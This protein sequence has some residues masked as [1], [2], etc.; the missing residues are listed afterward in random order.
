MRFHILMLTALVV[1]AGRMNPAM[2]AP[3]GGPFQ[4]NWDSIKANY[5]T[6]EWFKDGKFGIFMHWGLYSVPAHHSEW[7]VQ[8]MYRPGADQQWHIQNFGPVDKFGYKDF[9]PGFTAAKWDPDAWA[10]LF[11][12]AGVR[13]IVPT[14][15]HHD[16]FSLWDSALNKYNAKN[17]G[18]RRDLIGDLARAVRARGLKFGVSNHSMEHFSFIRAPRAEAK[19]DLYD[20]EWA[21]FYSVADRRDAAR[22]KFLELWV[23]KNLELIDKYH[24][25]M[26]WLDNGVNGRNLDPQKLKVV[27]YYYNRATEWGKSVTLSTKSSACVAGSIMDYERQGRILPREL[28]SFDWQ[29]DDPIGNK[30]G[31]VSE[32]QYKDAGLLVR[33]LVD[34]VSMNGNYLLNISPRA[35]GTIPQEQQDRL[36]AVGR[37]LAVNGEAIY[38]TRPWTRYGEGLYYDAPTGEGRG[39]D[40]PAAE[41]WTS[42][43]IRFTSRG[44]ALYAIVM[45]WPGDGQAGITSLAS[46]QVP[47]TVGRVE[48]LGHDGPLEFRQDGDGLHVKFPI[49]RPCDYA[50]VLRITGLKR[51]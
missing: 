49:E 14:A 22:Q 17:M 19:T 51:S 18:P 35:D 6:P 30:F 9:I 1:V 10:E 42:R 41:S 13:Y 26:L 25:D 48:L 40:D 46:G 43:E 11:R 21:G 7:Y 29:V 36:L 8:Y 28:K 34:C 38:G 3:P 31:Y 4:E 27:A 32:I 23:S 39:A 24:P 50:Y 44:D 5:R 45:D 37:W 47:G 16:G 12:K 33:R 20:P 15:E 2:A